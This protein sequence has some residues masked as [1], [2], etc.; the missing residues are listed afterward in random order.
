M[1][2]KFKP[3]MMLVIVGLLL[4]I[5]VFRTSGY[6][7][8]PGAIVTDIKEKAASLFDTK[9]SLTCV[10]GNT[11]VGA[12]SAEDYYVKGDGTGYGMCGAEQLVKD[13]MNYKIVGDES[14][15]GE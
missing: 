14:P 7:M 1:M 11:A 2:K 9:T 8:R 13:E 6:A 10:P 12:K 15:L 5:F 4:L 3:W